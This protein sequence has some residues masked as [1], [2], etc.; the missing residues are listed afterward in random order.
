MTVAL[1]RGGLL[2]APWFAH[3]RATI[4]RRVFKWL[5]FRLVKLFVVQQEGA[6]REAVAIRCDGGTLP[7][8]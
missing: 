7:S 6:Q 8:V 2:K 3:G 5:R 4:E 1:G